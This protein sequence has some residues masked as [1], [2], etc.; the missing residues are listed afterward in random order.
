MQP[1]NTAILFLLVVLAGVALW[2]FELR[3]GASGGGEK[4]PQKVF[5]GLDA[6]QVEWVELAQGDGSVLRV[7]KRGEEWRL[8][9]PLDFAADRFHADGLASGL[10]DL[11]SD[12]IYD[13]ATEDVALHPEP[14]EN[15]GVTREPRVRFGAA[16]RAYA[17][18]IGDPAPV[19]GNTYVRAGDEERVFAVPTWQTNAFGKTLAE[20]RE[21]RLAQF[22]RESVVKLTLAW[23]GGGATLEKQDGAWRVTAPLADAAD[24]ASVGSLLS[25]LETLRADA[26]LDA[27]PSDAELGLDAPVWR[28]EL[29]FSGGAKP[30]AVALGGPREG[31]R[32]A[33]RG[34]SAAVVEI[35]ASSLERLPKTVNALRDKQLARFEVSA[36]KRFT[37]AFT[38][39]EGG[40][41]SV[42][43]TSEADGWHSEPA[44]APGAASA[45]IA[46]LAGLAAADIAA[47]ALGEAERTGLG[48]APPRASL[49]VFGA[50]EGDAAPQLADVR[51]GIAKAGSGIAA[52]RADR[53]T[54]YWL[55]ESLA[56]QLPLSAAQFHESF[57]AK[58]GEATPPEPAAPPHVSPPPPPGE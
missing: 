52:Q 55:S 11:A 12:V 49:R 53:E 30:L 32:I 7:E 40:A 31:A 15:Y 29:T 44:M 51:L 14:L 5:A 54:I 26:F 33:A 38:G 22:D 21:A 4:Q 1:R 19:A 43:G 58:A 47:D 20:L 45:L 39:G 50:G 18:R 24:E 57:A 9:Q 27:P 35:P 13:P 8:V 16:G 3:E 28:A 34:V 23:S 46:E 37:L 17:L 6:K 36:A 56:A 42:T 48:L 25:D 10:A 41:L 2:R